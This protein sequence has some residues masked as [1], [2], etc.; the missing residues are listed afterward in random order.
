VTKERSVHTTAP[1]RRS[2]SAR[3]RFT[4]A[5]AAPTPTATASSTSCW[6]T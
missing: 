3:T 6:S 4:W 1:G 5:N 2:N